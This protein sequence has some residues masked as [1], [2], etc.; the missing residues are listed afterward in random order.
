MFAG[1]QTSTGSNSTANATKV[2]TG[3]TAGTLA[4][5]YYNITLEYHNGNGNGTLVVRS[6]YA[7]N[8]VANVSQCSHTHDITATF[9]SPIR[10]SVLPVHL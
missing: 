1:T 3:N 5:G 9:Q 10:P 2:W 4:A 7:A 6:G 8:S